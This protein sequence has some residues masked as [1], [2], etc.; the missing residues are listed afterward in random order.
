MGLSAQLRCSSGRS[1]LMQ[2]RPADLLTDLITRGCSASEGVTG[3]GARR[4]RPPR[5]WGRQVGGKHRLPSSVLAQHFQ[6]GD[7][8][9]GT[10]PLS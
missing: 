10:R 1:C 3:L 6:V 9:P 5:G 7:S 8:E 4:P 2:F